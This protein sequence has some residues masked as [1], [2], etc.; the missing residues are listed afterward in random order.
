MAAE[1]RDCPPLR[2]AYLRGSLLR[3]LTLQML[4]HIDSNGIQ[5][6]Y[7]ILLLVR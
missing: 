2:W 4:L 3:Y 7:P 6:L 1:T 5:H